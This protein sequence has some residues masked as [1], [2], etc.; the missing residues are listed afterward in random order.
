[1]SNYPDGTDLSYFDWDHEEVD[2]KC[3]NCDKWGTQTAC[4]SGRYN[5]S[6]QLVEAECYECGHTWEDEWDE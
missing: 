4:V 3:P 6:F 1:M 5:R 2:I